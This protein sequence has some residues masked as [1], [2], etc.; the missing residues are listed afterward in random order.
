MSCILLLTLVLDQDLR[1]GVCLKPQKEVIFFVN[2]YG[3]NFKQRVYTE[4]YSLSKLSN[5]VLS[6]I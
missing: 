2:E 4:E 3:L 6:E 5:Q 1:P